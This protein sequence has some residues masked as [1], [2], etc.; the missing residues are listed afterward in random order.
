[1]PTS[2]SVVTLSERGGKTTLVTKT[3]YAKPDDLA[4]V[5]KMGMEEGFS[6]TLDN[7]EAILSS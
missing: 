3:E 2:R 1:M 6:Q 5:L 7:L 4:M